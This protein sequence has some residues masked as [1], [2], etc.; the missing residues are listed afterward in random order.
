[1]LDVQQRGEYVYVALGQGGFRVYDISNIDNKDFSERIVTAPVSP[2]GQ[3]LYVKT[4][5][6]TAV[7]T[8]TT[9]GVDPL[10][11]QRPENEEQNIHLMYGF[12]YVA[13]K[14]EG[15]VVIGNKD[16]KRGTSSA[17]ARCSTATRPTT[18]SSGRRRSTRTA[19]STG[20]R[21]ITIAGT[22][23]YILTPKNLVV[24]SL[25]DPLDPKVDA[26]LGEA[27]G[28][29]DP[30]GVP[31][32]VPLRVRRGQGRAEGARRDVARQAADREGAG[33][34]VQ[35]R[36]QPLRRP[37]LRVRRRRPRRPRHRRHREARAADARA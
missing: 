3:R 5:Y 1:M 30:R 23:A 12:L 20:A 8:P 22:Y 17:S 27:E 10:R 25:E 21:R 4:K 26:E 24:V 19:C 15:L 18:S 37:H 35:G 11:K 14:E 13:D 16:P 9:L 34:A 29:V 28:L 32:P 7:A 36:A 2:F 33:R 31:D 6:A